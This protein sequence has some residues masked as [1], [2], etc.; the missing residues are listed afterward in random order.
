M[1][2]I[3]GEKIGDCRRKNWRFSAKNWLFSAKKLA[4]FGEKIGDFIDNKSFFSA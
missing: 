2:I 1:I 4:T 3:F